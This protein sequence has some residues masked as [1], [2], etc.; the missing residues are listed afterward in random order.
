MES[1][2]RNENI[3]HFRKLRD[4]TTDPTKRELILNLLAEVEAPGSWRPGETGDA[5]QQSRSNRVVSKD[6]KPR[7]V[8][9]AIL[10]VLITAGIV[11]CGLMIG[12]ATTLAFDYVWPFE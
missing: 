8:N 10:L 3:K 11:F 2:V 9:D 5:R 12:V 7:H 6:K 4:T 1:F